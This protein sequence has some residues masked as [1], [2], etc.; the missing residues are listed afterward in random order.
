MC[1]FVLGSSGEKPLPVWRWAAGGPADMLSRSSSTTRPY[2]CSAPDSLCPVQ[3]A[4]PPPL[5]LSSYT[6]APLLLSLAPQ[7][8]L[9][10]GP[11]KRRKSRPETIAGPSSY[12][13][14]NSWLYI[15]VYVCLFWG[16][17]ISLYKFETTLHCKNLVYTNKYSL[18]V[19]SRVIGFL[20]GARC[21]LPSIPPISFP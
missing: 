6:S 5:P 21:K 14:V 19:A 16:F 8:Q 9:I 4:N 17:G 20:A 1:A 12:L 10:R 2:H 11:E 7:V 18:F 3:S 13:Y 15:Y